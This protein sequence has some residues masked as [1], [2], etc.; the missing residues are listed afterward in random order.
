MQDTKA[1]S[2]IAALERARAELEGVLKVGD[3]TDAHGQE[4]ACNPVH[5]CWEQLNLAIEELRRSP[6]A[7]G[8]VELRHV[9]AQI[10]SEAAGEATSPPAEAGRAAPPAHSDAAPLF[11]LEDGASDAPPAGFCIPPVDVEEASVTFVVR[12]RMRPARASNSA[13]VHPPPAEPDPGKP[14]DPHHSP[15][16]EARVTIVKRTR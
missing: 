8:R 5:R 7:L 10:R 6:P 2:L 9:L 4:R 13:E 14:D 16:A 1:E 11:P 12:E 3:D 15:R